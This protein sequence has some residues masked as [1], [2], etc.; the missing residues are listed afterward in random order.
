LARIITSS[1][2]SRFQGCKVSK[3]DSFTVPKT[4][5]DARSI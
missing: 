5:L 1:D 2:S 3:F 4:I